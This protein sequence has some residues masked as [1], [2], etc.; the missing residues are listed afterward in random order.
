MKDNVLDE[1]DRQDPEPFFN[2]EF[3]IL[4]GVVGLVALISA[5][6]AR[7]LVF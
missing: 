2:K 1:F 5:E 6:I 4:L 7:H 3:E